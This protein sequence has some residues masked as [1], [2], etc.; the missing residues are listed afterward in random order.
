MNTSRRQLLRHAS[1]LLPA[2]LLP[3]LG[4]GCSGPSTLTIAYHPWPGYAPLKLADSLGWW[5]DGRLRSLPTGSASASRQALA[6]GH[7]QAAALTLDEVLMALADGL[8]LR[9]IGLFSLSHG[10]D[11][12]LARPG[13]TARPRWAGARLGYEAAAVGELMLAS[14]LEF[15]DMKADALQLMHL[16]YDQHERA[17]LAGEVD[18]LVTF[19]PVASR[20]QAAGAVRLFDS[21]QLPEERPI[22]DVLAVLLPHIGPQRQMLRRLLGDVLAAQRHLLGLPVDSSYRLAP[23]LDVPRPQVMQL[24]SGLRLTGWVDNRHWL[25]GEP[26]PLQRAARELAAFLQR[27][28][29]RAPERVPD[30]IIVAD[31]LPTEEPLG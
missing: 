16:P 27:A 22:A 18:L 12:V 6:S 24:F 8:P 31:F 5:D 13:D 30:A 2:A 7:A 4:S 3:A 19:E 20:L 10:A 23:W 15:V 25:L 9:V 17:W 21:S 14:W 11:V 26:A 29:L 1:A 28:G